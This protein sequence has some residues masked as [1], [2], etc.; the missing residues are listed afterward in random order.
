M[1]DP[2]ALAT[3]ISLMVTEGLKFLNEKQRTKF[4]RE[5]HEILTAIEEAKTPR[6]PLYSDL[7]LIRMQ[8][9]LAV[10]LQAFAKELSNVAPTS[11]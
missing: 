6:F 2:I 7:V 10:F 5:H 9:E 11:S 1:S 8:R 3:A 4:M